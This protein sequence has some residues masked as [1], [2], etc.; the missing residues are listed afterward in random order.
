[1]IVARYLLRP[2][3]IVAFKDRDCAW[4]AIA[5]WKPTPDI[6]TDISHDELAFFFAIT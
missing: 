2:P 3:G 6:E 4:T 5:T 1:M